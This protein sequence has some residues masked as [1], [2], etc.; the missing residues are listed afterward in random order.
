VTTK[1]N[2]IGLQCNKSDTKR[3]VILLTWYI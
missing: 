1:T 3:R 2:I